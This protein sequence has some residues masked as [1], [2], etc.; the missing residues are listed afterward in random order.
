MLIE[1]AWKDYG[2]AFNEACSKM[3]F[4]KMIPESMLKEVKIITEAISYLQTHQLK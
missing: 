1:V 2:K 3:E 4:L